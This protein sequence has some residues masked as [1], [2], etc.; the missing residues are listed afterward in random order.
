MIAGQGR[1]L[2]LSMSIILTGM[3]RMRP[4]FQQSLRK[5]FEYCFRSFLSRVCRKCFLI[6]A[7]SLLLAA[8]RLSLRSL[9]RDLSRCASCSR[10]SILCST[11]LSPGRKPAELSAGGLV[12]LI[13]LRSAGFIFGGMSP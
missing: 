11:F 7:Q 10:R 5:V 2:T 13:S 8:L 12:D 3:Q 1:P 6:S 9:M 4:C